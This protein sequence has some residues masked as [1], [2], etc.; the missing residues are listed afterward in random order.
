MKP[1]VSTPVPQTRL[2]QI[3]EAA[4]IL[5]VSAVTVRRRVRDGSLPHI[6][7][8]GR[9]YFRRNELHAYIEVHRGGSFAA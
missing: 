9:L 1:S 8:R 2:I 4:V 7:I 3:K 6:R 5:G